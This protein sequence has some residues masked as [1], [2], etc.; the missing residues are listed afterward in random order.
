MLLVLQT[1]GIIFASQYCDSFV[2]LAYKSQDIVPGI[3]WISLW[4]AW[5]KELY[6]AAHVAHST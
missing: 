4:E 1:W 2:D 5:K 3:E 6:D